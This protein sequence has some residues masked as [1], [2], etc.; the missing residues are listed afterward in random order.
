[1]LVD[2]IAME[3]VTEQ[4]LEHLKGLAYDKGISRK[5]ANMMS[6]SVHMVRIL[7]V[8]SD[9]KLRIYVC[10]EELLTN[11]S[12]YRRLPKDEINAP[13]DE[14]VKKYDAR[15]NS[16]GIFAIFRELTACILSL[17]IAVIFLVSSLAEF[18]VPCCSLYIDTALLGLLRYLLVN[19]A[20]IRGQRRK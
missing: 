1:M 17:M 3:V 11:E 12:R 9:E 10:F 4:M 13:F 6:Y 15:L 20:W 5:S 18:L 7:N 8:M 16:A 14:E 19:V 2:T